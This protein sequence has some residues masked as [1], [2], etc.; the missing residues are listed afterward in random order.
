MGY[1]AK[2]VLWTTFFAFKQNSSAVHIQTQQYSFLFNPQNSS[3]NMHTSVPSLVPRISM[4]KGFKHKSLLRGVHTLTGLQGKAFQ[5]ICIINNS[6]SHASMCKLMPWSIVKLIH[7][8]LAQCNLPLPL[9][10]PFPTLK[11]SFLPP[12]HAFL[13]ITS[14]HPSQ[15]TSQ[16]TFTSAPFWRRISATSLCPLYADMNKGVAPSWEINHGQQ[17]QT[18]KRG[19]SPNKCWTI[20]IYCPSFSH[21]TKCKHSIDC[22][23]A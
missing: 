15:I 13:W 14:V 8:Q 3:Q 2:I 11:P 4:R 7:G 22:I 20:Y 18:H 12:W 21:S 5:T 1:L 6:L 17:R 16:A 10:M 19:W 23:K 9:P